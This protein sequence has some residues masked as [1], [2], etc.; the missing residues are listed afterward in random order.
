[1]LNG[2][3]LPRSPKGT[4][5]LVPKPPWHYVGN[6]IAIEYEAK[7]EDIEA[8]LPK[9]L[10]YT[11]NR[12]CIYFVDWQYASENGQEYLNPLESQYKETII[13]MSATY[14]NETV[15]YCPYIWVDQ[16]KSLLRGLIQGWP[17]QFGE[18][19][20]TKRFALESKAAPK[21][22]CAGTLTVYG[23]RYIEGQVSLKTQSDA[24]PA[25]S[26]A[27]STLLRYYPNLQMGYHDKPLV[28]EL[29]QLKSRG[30]QIGP[31][32]RGDAQLTFTTDPTNELNDFR[33]VKVL[34]G[35]QFEVSLIVDDIKPLHKL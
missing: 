16:D 15:S 19:Q 17:K 8:Y 14:E 26:F 7:K 22:L 23:K 12:C 11:S 24:P 5:N 13:L 4:A 30:V 1:M 18:T 33:P 20:M 31:I 6:V 32:Q 21:D 27:G 25:P 3:S 2:F 9:P 35:Y 28:H 34:N 10:S 29:V